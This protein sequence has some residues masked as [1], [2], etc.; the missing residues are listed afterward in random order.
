M[1]EKG[2]ELV[3]AAQEQ[4]ATKAGEMREDAAFHVRE[5]IGQRSTRAG[6]QLQ[7]VAQ[8]LRSGG[9]QLRTGEDAPAAELVDSLA[10]HAENV[11]GYLRSAD[12]ER[13]LGDVEEFARRR[14]WLMAGCA[15]LAGLAASRVMKAS[16]DR[17]YDRSQSR[18]LPAYRDTHAAVPAGR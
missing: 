4:V 10:R 13:L 7:A 8:A 5:Q 18:R 2:G 1:K 14:P 15:A 6:E 17:R 12:P 3:S 9:E 11:G 16:S